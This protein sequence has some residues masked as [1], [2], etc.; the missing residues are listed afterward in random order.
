[1]APFAPDPQQRRVLD[2]GSGTLVVRGGFGT[3]KTA[4]LRERFV[5]LLERGADPERV[6]LVVASRSA[7]DETRTILLERLRTALPSLTVVT[8][9]GL[10][11][12]VLGRRSERLGAAL[13]P[14][15]LSSP[16]QFARVRELLAGEDRSAW[17]TYGPLLRMRGFADEV[18][19]FV[20][21][22]Q[23]ALLE[24]DDIERMA[25]DRGAEGW[26]ELAAFLRRYL[27]VL[28]SAG[29]SDYAG[30][31]VRG[32]AAAAADEPV[33]DHVLVDDHEDSTP[34]AE[35]LLAALRPASLV[36]AGNLDGHVDSFR[37]TTDAPFRRLLERG[38]VLELTATHRG[39]PHELDAWRAPHVSEEHG[40]IARELRRIH[41]EDGVAW[42]ELAV[43]VRRFGPRVHGLVRALDDAGVPRS[44]SAAS[45][46]GAVPSTR[47]FVLALRWIISDAAHRA[48]L[49]EPLLSSELGRMSPASARSFLRLVR[50]YGRDR[51]AALE[52]ADL[53]APEDAQGL[54][55][56]REILAR[57]EAARGSVLDAF[58]VLWT[59]LPYAHDLVAKADANAN[60][61][62][63][64]DEQ[65]RTDLDS[66]VAFSRMVAETGSADDP[67]VEGFL[68]A[69]ATAE[70][71]PER[72]EEAPQTDAV[73]VMSAHATAGRSFDTVIVVDALE[74]SFPS[75]SRPEP[76]FEL[77]VLGAERSRSEVNRARLQ[78]ERRLFTMVLRRARRR[79]LLTATDPYGDASA[80]TLTS[81]FVDE[82]G[83]RWAPAPGPVPTDPVSVTEAAAT[84]RRT[85][86]DRSAPALERLVA[87]EGVLALGEDPRRWWFQREW[88]DLGSPQR[89]ERH[90]SYSRLDTLENCEL[91]YVLATELGLD[92][93]GGYQAWV[94]KLVHSMIEDC[95]NGLIERS[96]AAFERVLDERWEETRFPSFAV[97]EAE[98]D[99]A[100]DVVIRNWFERYA[101]TDASATEQTFSFPFHGAVVRGKIDRIG[102]VPEGGT[103]ITDYKT[104]RSDNAGKAVDSLQLG[105]Y[106]LAVDE[107]EELAEHR[108]VEAVELAFL[109]GKRSDDHLDVKEWTIEESAAPDYVERMRERMSQ[110]VTRIQELDERRSYV[111]ST[112]ANCFFCRFQ[113]LCTRYPQ[114]DA[115]F[116]IQAREHAEAR[117][118]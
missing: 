21:R 90:L 84:W 46:E 82:L 71:A 26:L 76:M 51:G 95:E 50:A 27:D 87:L 77:S 38:P 108:P 106:Y 112:T 43:V 34:A 1:M 49:A 47:P 55:R 53:A 15:I 102:P 42:N 41:V 39:E 91:Q 105:I 17:P 9:H 33:F 4:A 73:H 24:P 12:H 111:A 11:F 60:G 80:I 25:R 20:V 14:T 31:L 83:L 35:A 75:L 7:R 104:G 94:G 74:G 72:A 28:D 23:E 118:T 97:S 57:A 65:A 117:S 109:G 79:V 40:A 64:A 69:L 19:Q 98:R 63:R 85:L 96:R 36:V 62:A 13:P 100:K 81:R 22:A 101:R 114:G 18:R 30:L 48:T 37:G 5:R 66:V 10:A 45:E 29:E 6:A 8:V 88:T 56:L 58:R 67:S 99:H 110:L 115:V 107:C 52:C 86:A 54:V 70:G 59:E 44:L 89:E 3:G 78:D 68:H 61:D 116:P 113:T 32:A 93:G 2:H 16:D 103:R 92:P